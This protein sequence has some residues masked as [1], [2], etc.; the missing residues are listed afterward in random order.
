MVYSEDLGQLRDQFFAA[1]LVVGGDQHDVFARRG[2][3]L[4]CSTAPGVSARTVAAAKQQDA[5]DV[6]Q[7]WK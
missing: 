1:V 3:V 4:P 2:P 5:S 7:E 6:S